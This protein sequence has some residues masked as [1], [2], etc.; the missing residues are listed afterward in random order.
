LF[1]LPSVRV[2]FLGWA[3]ISDLQLC[4]LQGLMRIATWPPPT[5]RKSGCG[6]EPRLHAMVMQKI[7]DTIEK[8]LAKRNKAGKKKPAKK[9]IAPANAAAQ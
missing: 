2:G 1:V 9:K 6:L 3:Q 4:N 8:D 7:T 5:Q